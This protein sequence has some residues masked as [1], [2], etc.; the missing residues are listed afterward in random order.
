MNPFGKSQPDLSPELL[1]FKKILEIIQSRGSQIF[2]QAEWWDQDKFVWNFKLYAHLCSIASNTFSK[3]LTPKQVRVPFLILTGEA[4]EVTLQV[5]WCSGKALK[6]NGFK[7][8][9]VEFYEMFQWFYDYLIQ[10]LFLQW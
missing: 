6:N 2:W 7:L 10:I 4:N 1:K 8:G 3:D 5:P 9:S